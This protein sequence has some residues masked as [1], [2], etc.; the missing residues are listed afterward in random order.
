MIATIGMGTPPAQGTNGGQPQGSLWWNFAPLVFIFVIFYF[1]LIR[2][3]KTQQKKLQ[4]MIANMHKGDE[5][6]TRGGIHG[7]VTAIN[8]NGTVVIES[9]KTRLKIGKEA[10]LH[11]RN[12]ESAGSPTGSTS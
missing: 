7:Q 2:P 4:Q 11:I 1:L 6:I 5:V 12:P 10:I 9:E 3:Q 8:N